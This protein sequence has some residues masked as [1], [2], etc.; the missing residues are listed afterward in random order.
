M[1]ARDQFMHAGGR[2]AHPEFIVLDF[3]WDADSHVF[4]QVEQLLPLHLQ[5]LQKRQNKTP[6][7]GLACTAAA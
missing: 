2:E 5:N 7:A 4:L 1:T 3:F 6:R